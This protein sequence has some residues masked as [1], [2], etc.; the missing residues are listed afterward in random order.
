MFIPTSGVNT[1][2]S[3]SSSSE[4]HLLAWTVA[5]PDRWAGVLIVALWLLL[6]YRDQA[7]V[8]HWL[9]KKKKTSFIIN[10]SEQFNSWGFVDLNGDFNLESQL[11]SW[12]HHL[13]SCFQNSAVSIEKANSLNKFF[14]QAWK[15]MTALEV[16]KRSTHP[17]QGQDYWQKLPGSKKVALLTLLRMI[18]HCA[19]GRISFL[20]PHCLPFHFLSCLSTTK[21]HSLL[22]H[23][24]TNII[25]SR[26]ANKQTH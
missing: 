5:E 17:D 1:N 11:L 26:T 13:W 3:I 15:A 19:S 25:S 8:P 16:K 14:W 24:E 20:M 9:K 12:G 10:V 4:H 21:C 6:F 18:K 22:F 2:F 23:N 7:R